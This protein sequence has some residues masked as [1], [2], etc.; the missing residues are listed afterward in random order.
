MDRR[1]GPQIA[2]QR[3]ALLG[4]FPQPLPLTAG[5]FTGDHSDVA[6]YV[7]AI[8][9][10]VRVSQEHFRRQCGHGSHP[11][12]RQQAERLGPLLDFL[13]ARPAPGSAAA[14]ARINAAVRPAFDGCSRP[15]TRLA[16]PSAHLQSTD[17]ALSAVRD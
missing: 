17:L 7:L 5:V 9:E 11:G 3:V 14:I 13:L 1:F 6:G 10:A 8:G 15:E 4:S 16:V 2:Q 12:M